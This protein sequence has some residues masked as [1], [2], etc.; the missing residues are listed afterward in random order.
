MRTWPGLLIAVLFA[1]TCHGQEASSTPAELAS[2]AQ[3][4]GLW[5]AKRVFEPPIEGPLR[6]VR[7]DAGWAGEIAGRTAPV[8]GS[9]DSIRF[10]LPE[11]AGTFLGVLADSESRII[12]HWIQPG[13][14]A[15]GPYASP[16]VL[17]KKAPGD[18]RGTVSPLEIDM[19][20]YLVVK[21][22]DDGSAGIYLRN[23]ERNVGYFQFPVDRLERDGNAVKL[24]ASGQDGK[25]ERVL[26]EGRYDPEN[27]RISI[28]FPSRGGTY[29]F[30]RIGEQEPSDFYPRG[31]PPTKYAYSP[32]PRHDDGWRTASLEEVGI[33]RAVITKF[34]QKLIDTPMD[35][36][37]APE[38]HGVLI[39]RHGKLVLEEY[40]HGE[41]RERPH[42]T[43]SAGKSLAADIAGAAMQAGYDLNVSTPVYTAM[44]GG[45]IPPDLDQRKRALTL[46]HLLTMSSGF[47]C[48]EDNESS[49][50][51]EDNMNVPDV[52][53][54]TLE[55]PMVRPPGEKAVYCS[56][57]ANLAGGVVARA[58]RQPSLPLFHRLIADP[59]GIGRYYMGVTPT[60]DYYLGG[61][62][63]LLP[64]DFL[65]LAQ[66]HLD[67]GVWNGKQIYSPDWSRKAT[68]PLVR[69]FETS[70]SRYGYL[71]WVYD[72]PYGERT[73]R[74][75][76]ASGNGGQLSIGIDELD[77]AIVFYAGNYNDWETGLVALKEYIPQ[78]ILPA[79]QGG[80]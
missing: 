76:F 79:V 11:G 6:I 55:L 2:A 78:D 67:G 23:P 56:V 35:S 22:R 49:P 21:L 15:G 14:D 13:T 17:L 53:R 74:A 18:W 80:R 38:V 27:D 30:R 29:D 5:Q 33:D 37:E 65:K 25:P 44:N 62:A 20:F 34:I 40:F 70:K 9:H 72:F 68:S 58:A 7:S 45:V 8:Q 66:V 32:P 41:H 43:R 61:G 75:Y 50:G 51:Y 31:R 4:A 69:F 1:A 57:G 64:R 12:G 28:Y 59:L 54:A 63:R 42:D 19:T 3:L 24:V 39:A 77:L 60:H 36:A 73:V 46:E 16:V 48:D 26:L 52:Y 71:W 10:E 47:D